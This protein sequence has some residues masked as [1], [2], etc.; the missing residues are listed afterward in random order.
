MRYF[1]IFV[2]LKGR[3]VVV[4][5]AGEKA[6]QKLRLLTKTNASIAVIGT[7]AVAEIANLAASGAITHL[8]RRPEAR[9]LEGAAL[10]FAADDEPSV[11]EE[12]AAA[13]AA[14]GIPV[15]VVDGPT[16][17]TFIM[18]AIVD[19]APVTVAIGTE[20]TAPVLARMIKSRIEA[21]LP[22]GFGNVATFARRFR[23][24][25]HDEI[26]SPLLRRRFWERLL[27]GPF[28]RHALS[29]DEVSATREVMRE[30]AAARGAASP[31]GLVTLIGCGP[32]NPDLLTLKAQQ[33]LQE[34]DVLV[35]DRLVDPAILEYARRDALR[36]DAGKTAG[37]PT[38]PQEAINQILVREALKGHRVARLKGG[39]PFVFGRA[40]EEMAAVRAAGIEVEVVPGVTAAHAAAASI[41]LP[42]TLRGRVRQFS[43]VTGAADGALNLDWKALSAGGQAFAIYMGVRSAPLIQEKLVAAGADPG[44]PVV[45]VEKA[46]LPCE[47]VIATTLA[48]L[49]EAIAVE[50]VTGPAI[51]FVGLD[52]DAARLSRPANVA[53]FRPA[54]AQ[55]VPTAPRPADEI[56]VAAQWIAG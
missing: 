21:W 53:L 31:P 24:R 39:D 50:K 20:G 33:R 28:R 26:G 10:V 36:I 41:G 42:M 17:S 3:R 23:Q 13:S 35:Y 7:G 29:G 8:P 51:I 48:D 16:A 22:A 34:A 46:T 19:R 56:T 54:R 18:P 11:N 5:G 9:D 32:G 14:R 40:A 1:P 6:A 43:L 45:I 52:W 25:V 47:R 30:I 15:N 49:A 2:D 38:M 27:A 37:G 4:A 44:T 12:I 55:H